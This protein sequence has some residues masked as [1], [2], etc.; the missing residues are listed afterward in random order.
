MGKLRSPRRVLLP[1]LTHHWA[2]GSLCPA[3]LHPCPP[4]KGKLQPYS[5]GCFS[6]VPP[7]TWILCPW[8]R[9]WGQE[10]GTLLLG[11]VLG[12]EHSTPGLGRNQNSISLMHGCRT[13]DD[14][15]YK[16]LSSPSDGLTVSLSVFFSCTHNVCVNM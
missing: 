5:P 11:T 14:V 4:A 9:Q 6:R 1:S 13:G 10:T 12:T 15:E 8:G 2:Q 16:S 3:Q 7:P